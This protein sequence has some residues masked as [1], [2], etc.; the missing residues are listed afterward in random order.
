MI[1]LE[2]EAL[3]PGQS[4]KKTKTVPSRSNDEVEHS[5]SESLSKDRKS[6]GKPSQE[7]PENVRDTQRKSS[8]SGSLCARR[9]DPDASSGDEGGPDKDSHDVGGSVY[10]KVA[11][12]S[13]S[14]DP[15]AA[16]PPKFRKPHAV[17]EDQSSAS[18]ESSSQHGS[19][20]DNE[21]QDAEKTD[22]DDNGLAEM[23]KNPQAL[24]E[25]F[26]QEIAHWVDSNEEPSPKTHK[27]S[28]SRLGYPRT[29]SESPVP[30]RHSSRPPPSSRSPSSA[31]PDDED[32]SIPSA[33]S[34]SSKASAAGRKRMIHQDS[35]NDSDA[36]APPPKKPLKKAAVDARP[37]T[38]TSKNEDSQNK[39]THG[40]VHNLQPQA[41]SKA[42]QRSKHT[43]AAEKAAIKGATSRQAKSK[44][45]DEI[46]KFRE[47]NTLTKSDMRKPK[48]AKDQMSRA[49]SST[50]SRSTKSSK[51][52]ASD[53][54]SGAG[55]T[56]ATDSGAEESGIEIVPP[57]SGKLKL[58]DQHRRVCRVL[59]HSVHTVLLDVSLK[60]AYPDGPEKH[61]Q[62]AYKALLNAAAEFGYGDIVKRLKKK[63][64]YAAELCKI[65]SQRIP[66]FRGQVRKLVEGQPCTAF[67]LRFGDKVK[68]DWL[69]EG[70][71]YIYPFDYETKTIKANQ[72]YSPPVYL[73][74]LR[75]AF[76]KR[77][78]SFGFNVSPHFTSSLLDKPDEK[79]MPAPLLALVATALHAAIED[80]KH[81]YIQPHDFTANDYWNVYTD[82][83]QHLSTIRSQGPA[84]YH[85]LMHGLWRQI[86]SPMGPSG[87]AGAPRKNF[88]DVGAMAV[89]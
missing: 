44:R 28:R 11:S 88:L 8:K 75:V 71:R 20:S 51:Q 14:V 5:S 37:I 21:S 57:R 9:I 32:R 27:K 54:E 42:Y 15:T 55:D 2:W 86:S 59:K 34:L 68:G 24:E 6:R 61:G 22:D 17:L 36:E 35:N 78:S 79:E 18:D 89:E 73:E 3:I 60:N 70:L 26:A 58:T 80:C 65:P 77:S 64:E 50:G 13:D 1:P 12:H 63:D 39:D 53:D 72:P 38:K 67:G 7:S 29:V 82:H 43:S 84:Q 19:R 31:A 62:T 23:E 74:T 4:R 83:I 45:E 66:T 16:M 81:G 30:L 49:L 25:T 10:K 33:K 52:T 46:P 69:Q 76:F 48:T 47:I 85:V 41:A 40:H 87:T 56:S